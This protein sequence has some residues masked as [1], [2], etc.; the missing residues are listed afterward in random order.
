L[1]FPMKTRR[2]LVQSW[3]LSR[4]K[5]SSHVCAESPR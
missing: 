4:G 5:C 2:R 1:E 3:I